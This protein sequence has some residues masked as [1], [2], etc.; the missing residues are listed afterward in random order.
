VSLT[1][2]ITT[3]SKVGF[4]CVAVFIVVTLVRRTS[5]WSSVSEAWAMRKC[6]EVLQD[7]LDVLLGGKS[8]RVLSCVGPA[9]RA[10]CQVE[11]TEVWVPARCGW[12]PS[13][14]KTAPIGPWNCTERHVPTGKGGTLMSI[15]IDRKAGWS[16]A[17]LQEMV[18][19]LSR[20][21]KQLIANRDTV[22]ALL[23]AR[24]RLVDAQE[25]VRR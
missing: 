20:H 15:M 21:D 4:F 16:E 12:T 3:V 24:Q 19:R 25:D 5:A 2:A 6:P 18:G 14:M 8:P 23:N 11:T 13:V 22:V 17:E 1:R 10:V 9:A 7:D